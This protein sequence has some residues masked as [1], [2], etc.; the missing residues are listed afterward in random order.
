MSLRKKL[1]SLLEGTA[2]V[3]K[4]DDTKERLQLALID[5]Q[6][7]IDDRVLRLRRSISKVISPDE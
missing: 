7:K 6:N 5:R 2:K 3:L 1:A 4:E